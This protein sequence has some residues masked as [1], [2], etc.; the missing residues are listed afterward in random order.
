MPTESLVSE[1]NM[2]RP[3]NARGVSIPRCPTKPGRT[4]YL[5]PP[6]QYSTLLTDSTAQK[7]RLLWDYK[8][9]VAIP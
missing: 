2:R 1:G 7:L 5:P 6:R 3:V 4:R 8:V 9:V